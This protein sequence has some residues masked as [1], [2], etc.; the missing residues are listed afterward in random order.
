M[1]NPELL[2]RGEAC[3][4]NHDSKMVIPLHTIN[5][6]DLLRNIGALFGK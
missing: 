2:E 4:K 6:R 1:G 3:M 5:R